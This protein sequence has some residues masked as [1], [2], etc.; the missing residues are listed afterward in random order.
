MSLVNIAVGQSG[1]PTTVINA[2]LYGVIKEACDNNDKIDKIYGMINGIEGF[3]EGKVIDIIGKVSEEEIELLKHTPAAYLGS[4]RYKLPESMEDSIYR[5]IFEKF[6]KL[7]IK[8]FI[9]IG[10]NDS[11]DTVHKLS[12]YAKMTNSPVR[13]IGVPKTIDNDLTKTDHSPGYGSAAKYVATTVRDIVMDANVYDTHSVTIIELMGRHAGWITAASVLARKYKG[14]NPVLIYL[15]EVAFDVKKFVQRV[16]LELNKKHNVIVCVSEGIKDSEGKFICEYSSEAGVDTFGHKMLTGCGKYLENVIKEELGVKVRSVEL[17]VNQ[18][19]KAA[20]ASMTDIE[21]AI[22]AG[23]NGVKAGLNGETGKMIAMKR[24]DTEEYSIV[25]ETVDCSE[26]CNQEKVV[27]REWI[28]EDGTDILQGFIDYVLPLIQ[29]ESL[30]PI[31]NGLP[32][33]CYRK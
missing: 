21:E 22:M 9:Y 4:C 28:S 6:D 32:K 29:G 23:R 16:K 7:N 30:T 25:Y 19:C 33:Y 8:Y 18:R 11:M 2:S 14:D 24:E 5:I 20:L 13:I 26:V 17:N 10:G 12:V 31:E 3:I 27:P 15:P 1:G